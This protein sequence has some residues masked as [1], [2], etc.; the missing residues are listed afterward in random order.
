MKKLIA[1]VLVLLML[2][3]FAASLSSCV[4]EGGNKP[5]DST[6]ETKGET[7][8][9]AE[10]ES[11][12]EKSDLPD[13]YDLD[14]Y[15]F[16]FAV[17]EDPLSINM[18]F[19]EEIISEPV[20]DAMYSR[21]EQISE[22]YNFEVENN[23]I[24]IDTVKSCII[25]GDDLYDAMSLFVTRAVYFLLES[26][27]TDLNIVDNLNL[28][29]NYWDQNFNEQM[30]MGGALY[31][32]TGA[33]S[34]ADDDK[35]MVI[36]Y[37]REMGDDYGI[38]NLY[39]VAYAGNW[40]YDV[41][42]KYAKQVASDLNYDNVID[43]NDVIGYMYAS[44]NLLAPH[45]AATNMRLTEKDDFDLP[46]IIT[47]TE[48]F[49][50]AFDVFSPIFDPSVSF[51]WLKIGDSAV[52]VAGIQS[53]VNTRHVLFQNMILSQL[54]RLYRDVES[55][56]GILP[57]PKADD[58]QD[59][60]STSI[61]AF[62]VLAIP[63]PNSHLPE[64]GFIIEALAAGSEKVTDAYYNICLESKFVRDTESFDMINMMR[65]NVNYD[66]AYYCDFGGLFSAV[67]SSFNSNKNADNMASAIASK[68]SAAEAAVERFVAFID[69]F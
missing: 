31:Y 25:A 52:Q 30:S 33:I 68:R 21:N 37:N 44:N 32:M 24:P 3:T 18:L 53:L 64:T 36:M 63:S 19:P 42:A 65:E 49:I 39:D 40:T 4:S 14:G 23:N 47:D 57:M 60:Y 54:R 26:Y 69:A 51:D 66:L 5:E 43:D 55:E 17:E 48:D 27:T 13:S 34:V 50:G 15:L 20:N 16:R 29:K 11:R 22:K 59:K 8:P 46:Y 28:T 10:S 38:E 2:C 1:S 7:T 61:Y 62:D 56:F 41:M 9:A 45:L 58:S 6:A 67:T 35:L 12:Y